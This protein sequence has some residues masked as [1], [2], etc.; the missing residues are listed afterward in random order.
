[1]RYCTCGFCSSTPVLNARVGAGGTRSLSSAD[2]RFPLN[3]SRRFDG[4]T[5]KRKCGT[6]PGR[7]T[8]PMRGPADCRAKRIRLCSTTA[9][10]QNR[11]PEQRQGRLLSMKLP[12]LQACLAAAAVVALMIGFTTSAQ[13]GNTDS[14]TLRSSTRIWRTSSPA[15]PASSRHGRSARDLRTSTTS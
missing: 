3:A 8:A 11:G 7:F 13:G 4:R 9:S 5:T 12:A 6:T 1:M 14:R 2:D 10:R 15:S